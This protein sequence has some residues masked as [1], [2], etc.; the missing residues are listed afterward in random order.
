MNIIGLT[1]VY[2]TLLVLILI[3]FKWAYEHLALRKKLS[4]IPGPDSL[5]FIGRAWVLRKV[6][7]EGKNKQI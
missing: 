2:S 1:F 5:P 6:P 4:S 7:V 3:V